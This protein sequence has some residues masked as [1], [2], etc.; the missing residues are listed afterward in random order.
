VGCVVF[1]VLPIVGIQPGGVANAAPSFVLGAIA[2][3]AA[4]TRVTYR[5]RAVA[6]IVL[7]VLAVALG[8][9][10]FGPAGGIAVGGAAWGLARVVAATLLPAALIFRA[11]YR[12]FAGA[13]WILG[14][15]F[16]LALPF[17]AHSVFLLLEGTF[18][19]AQAGAVLAL[20]AVVAGLFGF[21][22]AETTAAASYTGFAVIFGL[23]AELAL[24]GFSRYT[25]IADA[26]EAGPAIAISAIAFAA[27]SSVIA[28]GIFQVL[29]SRFAAAARRIDLHP[30]AKEKKAG[31]SESNEWSTR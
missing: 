16:A 15:A 27:M 3:V 20:G 17:A 30:K 7:G 13:R 21:M 5:Q 10:G 11:R 6:M 14:V 4:L 22:G 2:L 25:D 18:G 1:G 26:L 29:A 12:A 31:L 23:A 19:F 9:E 8:L 28:L 24:E